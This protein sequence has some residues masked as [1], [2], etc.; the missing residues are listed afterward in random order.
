MSIEDGG[1]D[2]IN[3][4]KYATS[5]VDH[6]DRSVTIRIGMSAESTVEITVEDNGVGI[7]AGNIDRIFDYG[8]TTREEGHGFGLHSARDS[9]QEIGAKLVKDGVANSED[10]V[11]GVLT[12][13]FYHLYGPIN[14]YVDLIADKVG[15]TR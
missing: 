6:R 1:K 10:D 14:E 12:N 7:A 8:F 9:A 15:G 11:N 2:D 4:A 5:G 3:N 13:G